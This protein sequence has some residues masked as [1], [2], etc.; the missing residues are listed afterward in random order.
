MIKTEKKVWKIT[1]ELDD[2]VLRNGGKFYFAKDAT[3][4]PGI[5]EKFFPAK[6]LKAISCFEE[7]IRS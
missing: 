5:P 4:R 7:K 6:N 1:Y 2:I 3:L